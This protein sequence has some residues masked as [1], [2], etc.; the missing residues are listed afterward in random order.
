[1]KPLSQS[2][3]SAVAWSVV[4]LKSLRCTEDNVYV[5]AFLFGFD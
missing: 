1:M 4:I 2:V 5:T 3:V